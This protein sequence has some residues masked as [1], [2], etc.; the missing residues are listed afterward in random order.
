LVTIKKYAAI[1][2]GSNAVRLLIASVITPKGGEPRFKKT[3]LVRVPIRLGTDVFVQGEISKGNYKRL[4]T[5]LRAFKNLMDVHQV[6]DYMACAT[7]AMREAKNGQQI[8]RKLTEKTGIP[9]QIIN[10]N[11]EATLIASTKINDYIKN[12]KVYLYVDVGGGSTEFSIISQGKKVV[13]KSFK[14]GTVR[15]LNNLVKEKTWEAVKNWIKD[16]TQSFDEVILLGSGGNI[17]STY[18]ASNTKEGEPLNYLYLISYFEKVKSLS[19]EERI[20]ALNMN[21]D[22]ADV[23]EPALKIYLSAMKWSGAKDIYVPKIG[24]SDGIIRTLHRQNANKK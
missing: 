14:L 15:I 13:S 1:D 8:A 5:A 22:R 9:I 4:K 12:D 20:V 23:I 24:L 17:N 19:L 16:Q 3:S 10:G 7:S 18:K 2:I 6:S 11:K 21:P